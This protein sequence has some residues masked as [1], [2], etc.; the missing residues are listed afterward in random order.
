MTEHD[1]AIARLGRGLHRTGLEAISRVATALGCETA[2]LIEEK[3]I[4]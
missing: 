3:G 4:A 1:H 2:L